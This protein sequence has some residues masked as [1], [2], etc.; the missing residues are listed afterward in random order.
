MKWVCGIPFTLFLALALALLALFLY[1]GR[2][3]AVRT[4]AGMDSQVVSDQQ[5]MAELSA[6]APQLAALLSDPEFSRIT[7]DD[8]AVLDQALREAGSAAGGAEALAGMD[9]PGPDVPAGDSL[10]GGS[11]QVGGMGFAML[12]VWMMGAPAHAI[13]GVLLMITMVLLLLTGVPYLF[14]SRRAGRLVNPALSL[15]LA[16]WGPFLA[17]EVLQGRLNRW[18]EAVP[19]TSTG[20]EGGSR[21]LAAQLAQ[22]LSDHFFQGALPLYRVASLLAVAMFIGAAAVLAVRVHRARGAA[23]PSS[24]ASS[25]GLTTAH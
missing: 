5:L 23:E 21:V 15:A 3:G 17:L 10:S 1:S 6:A 11:G 16:G 22:P 9:L 12:P 24:P 8:P 18:L 4:L 25:R 2:T 13:Y 20:E 14:L 7:Y 19:V